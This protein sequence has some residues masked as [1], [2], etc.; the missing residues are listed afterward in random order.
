MQR[1]LL[2]STCYAPRAWRP[3]AALALALS[4]MRV[5]HTHTPY[6]DYS[7]PHKGSSTLTDSQSANT[8]QKVP[9]A[10]PSHS[11]SKIGPAPPEKEATADRAAGPLSSS[12]SPGDDHHQSGPRASQTPPKP[13]ETI[14]RLFASWQQGLVSGLG[15]VMSIGFLIFLFYAPVKEDT[16]HHTAVVASEALGNLQLK[17]QVIQLSKDVVKAV[18]EDPSSM[19]LVVEFIEKML[20]QDDT[21]IAVSSLLQSLFED[22]YTQEVTKKFVLVI[23][24]DPWIQDQLEL[25]SKDI[26]LRLLDDPDIKAA[27][28]AFLV[29]SASDSLNDAELHHETARA[30]RTAVVRIFN[31]WHTYDEVEK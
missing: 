8:G 27:L 31:P 6:R 12:T 16:V 2:L 3:P 11:A 25:L 24:R 17:N 13:F 7:T 28:S 19:T 9:P 21:K 20:S 1:R 26:V 10:T 5:V 14:H 4:N 18:L 29:V 22:H 15:I 23:V 30:I